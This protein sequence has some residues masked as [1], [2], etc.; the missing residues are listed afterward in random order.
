MYSNRLI[1]SIEDHWEE[2]A[3]EAIRRIRKEEDVPHIQK[4]SDVELQRWARDILNALQRKA[5]G[6]D[7]ETLAREYQG[8]G[9]LRFETSVNLYEVVR[10]L[11][12][13]KIKIIEFVRNRGFAQ[14]SMEIY[15]QEELEHCIGLFFDWVLYN[16]VRGYEDAQQCSARLGR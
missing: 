5:L 6:N 16:I 11:H 10:C 3:A 8:L 4:L 12:I 13:L 7:D 15:A 9:R 14:N 2:I 1:Q